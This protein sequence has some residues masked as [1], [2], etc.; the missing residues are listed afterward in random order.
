M[1]NAVKISLLFGATP[2]HE[3]ERPTEPWLKGAHPTQAEWG[4]MRSNREI[5]VGGTGYL[6]ARRKTAAEGQRVLWGFITN[7][8]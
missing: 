8:G 5:V 7:D 4:K 3:P 6:H 1:P 2:A